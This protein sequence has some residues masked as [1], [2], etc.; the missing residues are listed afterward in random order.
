MKSGAP[1][2]RQ[3]RR[4][5]A[6][7]RL[8]AP[9]PGLGRGEPGLAEEYSQATRPAATGTRIASHRPSA[10]A[11]GKGIDRA[12]RRDSPPPTPAS[13]GPNGARPAPARP[14]RPRRAPA[15]P[16]RRR[17][18]RGRSAPTPPANGANSRPP[19]SRRASGEP[20]RPISSP[21]AQPEVSPAALTRVPSQ[22]PSAAPIAVASR[23]EGTGRTMS[24]ASSAAPARATASRPPAASAI[25]RASSA[26]PNKKNGIRINS[27]QQKSCGGDPEQGKMENIR[28]HCAPPFS[29]QGKN[30][31][32]SS[33]HK[34]LPPQPHRR[35]PHPPPKRRSW[36]PPRGSTPAPSG[37][38]DPWRPTRSPG[39]SPP[40]CSKSLNEV[41]GRARL[42]DRRD[43]RRQLPFGARRR[44]QFHHGPGR[45][46]PAQQPDQQPRRSLRFLRDRPAAGRA[47]RGGARR[48]LG[49]ARLRRPVGGGQHPAAR[50]GPGRR[51]R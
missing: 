45:R 37:N 38:R 47:D 7:A 12:D 10:V 21:T 29:R 51:P 26:S 23:L 44:A 15:P 1:L 50:A 48:G 20:A 25:E 31:C 2:Q 18:R 6:R 46:D 36:S 32:C 28:S 11:A 22:G 43:R 3:R 33:L 13:A 19:S 35:P 5:A 17:A 41:A 40:R 42:L 8:L 9:A 39:C 27:K 14:P 24:S 4:P 49:G 30:R 34:S 16:G